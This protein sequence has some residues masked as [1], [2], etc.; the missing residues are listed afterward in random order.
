MQWKEKK[1]GIDNLPNSP[2]VNVYDVKAKTNL[3]GTKKVCT[4][5]IPKKTSQKN[6]MSRF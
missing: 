1:K 5:T 4:H 3:L 2:L 6:E